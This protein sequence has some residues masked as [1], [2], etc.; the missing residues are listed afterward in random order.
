MSKL[1]VIMSTYREPEKYIRL[2]VQSI[3]DQS[4]SD[5]ELIVVIDDPENE[6]MERLLNEYRSQDPRVVVLKNERNL[7]LVGSLNRALAVAHGEWI[8]RMD[9][10]DVAAPDRFEKELAYL[11]EH[12][13]DLVGSLVHR[14]DE[15][16]NLL[17]ALDSRHYEPSVVM[18][19]LR[20]ADCV[21]HPTWLLKRE[22]YEALGGYR[23]MPRCEDYDFLLRALKA[24]YRIG[25][26][27]DFLLNYR[28]SVGGI[29]QS[30]LLQ[31]RLSAKYLSDN[32]D[33]LE[34][35]TEA[36][37]NQQVKKQLTER[38]VSRY[39]KAD[40]LFLKARRFGK[41][42]PF[43]CLFC[44]IASLCISKHQ[45]IRFYDMLKLRK[46]RKSAA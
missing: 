45:R 28:I 41:R 10:D 35:V 5:F 17:T 3:L 36:E 1:S 4:V 29:S 2:S 9:S 46:L 14:M 6:P 40:A 43:R 13:L 22:V 7:G 44:L 39:Q 31:Q 34:Q 30:G 42:K 21:P 38:A 18:R 25:L 11:Q 37:V 8:A 26:C 19:S 16:G 23:E 27:D 32:F 15:Q 24:G 20:I 12:R 33:R